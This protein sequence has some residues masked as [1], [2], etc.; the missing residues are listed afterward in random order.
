MVS[1]DY[2]QG[3]QRY[4]LSNYKVVKSQLI[5]ATDAGWWAYARPE[6]YVVRG[7]YAVRDLIYLADNDGRL[8]SAEGW[9]VTDAFGQGLQRYY[10]YADKHAAVA[11]FS[12]D[13]WAHYT[14]SA[15]YVLR[16]KQIVGAGMLLA[17]NDGLL[18][19]AV[20]SEGWLVTDAYDGELQRYRIDDSCEGHLGAHL[21]FFSIDENEYYG[22]Y[23]QG[24]ELRGSL[25]IEGRTW[26]ADND[27]RVF[28]PIVAS[29]SVKK[30][31]DATNIES[32]VV[33]DTVYLF[34]PS[35]ASLENVPLAALLSTGYTGFYI[36]N[37]EDSEFQQVDSFANV[38]LKSIASTTMGNG[39]LALTYK[40]SQNS[41]VRNLAVMLSSDV[42]S[43]FVLSTDRANTGRAYVEASADHSAKAS[44]AI[45]VVDPEGT[46][47]YNKD[48]VDDGKLSS[49]KG[50]GN[51]SWGTGNK[52]P[53]QIALNKKA[54]LL[55]TG[56]SA[57]E[58]KK[59][60]LLANAN[61]A[62]LLHDTIAYNLALEMGMVG[63]ECRPVDLWYDGEYRGSY[64][65]CEKI[66]VNS[67]RV[68]IHDLESDFEDANKGVD[69]DSLPVAMGVNKYGYSYQYV[70]GVADPADITGGY[71]LEMDSA[72]YTNEKC[73]FFTSQGVIVVKSPE[74]CSENA[75]R[76][77][78]EAFQAALN[79]LN[80][81][82]EAFSF[83]LG[84]FA[85]AYLLNEFAKNGD[86]GFSST[87]YYLDKT[88]NSIVAAPV[89]DF[90]RSM[91]TDRMSELR[92]NYSGY[93]HGASEW[94]LETPSVQEALKSVYGEFSSLVHNVLLGNEGSVGTSGHLH[95]IAYYH[96]EIAQSQK[97]DEVLYGLTSFDNCL[98]PYSTYVRNIEY[99]TEW[100]GN[101]IAWLDDAIPALSGEVGYFEP[102]Y[103]EVN[104]LKVFD[105]TYYKQMNPDVV[106]VYGD[107]DE[108]VFQHF[109]ECGMSEGRV[110]ARNFNVQAYKNNYDDLRAAFGD[111]LTAY[112]LHYI[113]C[114]FYEGRYA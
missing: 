61:D 66:E 76:Y 37:G 51:T 102:I 33:G 89:W 47:I 29:A 67:G 42:A 49:I 52:K 11:G 78:S 114:G 91:G 87:Y 100:I 79:A 108:A 39:A 19:E 92:L 53:Y 112:Y 18:V 85:K 65:L 81:E 99:L 93:M 111:D 103:G 1:E 59:W 113:Q 40:V 73:Y 56:D 20:A 75:M 70:A 106:D 2:G 34:L 104:Y 101:R 16:G 25:L 64:L 27:G 77:I 35:Y 45:V 24:Y 98:T 5:D 110:A 84:T 41:A 9:L 15:G 82:Y 13:G 17:D 94:M 3:L 60:V 86:F 88:S 46:V 31:G 90:D 44:V 12:D 28:T 71:L 30:S 7:A 74:V 21:G 72:Y 8:A 32:T 57:N 36:G 54:D 4:W 58:K 69:F 95:S 83:D 23:D 26:Y 10:V 62:T 96:A 6:G 55:Q 38:N 48:S 80:G 14:T 43:V 68:D 107:S 97:M 63:V 109:I 50:R 22:R 105:A